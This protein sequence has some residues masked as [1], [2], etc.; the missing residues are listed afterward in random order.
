MVRMLVVKHENLSSSPRY[1][2]RKLDMTVQT[3][4]PQC[5]GKGGTEG[6]VGSGACWPPALFH[7]WSEFVRGWRQRVSEQASLHWASLTH[8]YVQ[9]QHAHAH[10]HTNV[11]DILLFGVD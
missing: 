2:G 4:V 3:L 6:S 8:L 5:W 11:F 10:T 1:S 9:A 7:V